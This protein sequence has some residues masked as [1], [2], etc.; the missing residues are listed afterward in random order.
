MTDAP[1]TPDEI[2][3]LLAAE[4]VL[5][6]QDLITRNA[7]AERLGKEPEFAKRVADWENRLAGLNT[8]YASEN[9]PDL[10]PAIEARL[11]PKGAR[12][13]IRLPGTL[14]RWIS[15]AVVA[16][17]VVLGALV[18]LP[19]EK[20]S[21]VARL[22]TSDARLTYE[23]RHLGESLQITRTAGLP[24]G[25]GLVHE[26]WLIVP[27]AAPVSLGLLEADQLEVRYPVPTA[28]WTLAV[29]LEPAGG[30]RSGLPSGPVILSAQVGAP[31]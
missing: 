13:G 10:L 26:L 18:M 19:D 27:D 12:S 17:A 30:S 28:G 2:D 6:V 3:D 24:A 25:E 23:V 31:S 16:A 22:S 20:A 1:L 11:F 5:G 8:G 15:G 14:L 4:Y 9:A 29:S 7:C 21:L